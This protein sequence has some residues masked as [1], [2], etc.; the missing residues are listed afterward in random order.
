MAPAQNEAAPPPASLL[1]FLQTRV[2]GCCDV[3]PL[4]LPASRCSRVASEQCAD[5]NAS[6]VVWLKSDFRTSPSPPASRGAT[7]VW[8]L[9]IRRGAQLT[10]RASCCGHLSVNALGA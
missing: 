5:R 10:S 7:D 9:L 3:V 8:N 1:I 2:V 4:A 6:P